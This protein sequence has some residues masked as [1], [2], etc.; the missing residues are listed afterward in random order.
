VKATGDNVKLRA[1]FPA[2]VVLVGVAIVNHNLAGAGSV[3]LVSGSGLNEAITVPAN[4]G[5]QSNAPILDFSAALLAQRTSTTFDLEV[6]GG[7]L[8]NIAIGQIV[9][10]TAIRDFRWNWG[11]KITPMRLVSRRATFGATHLQYDKRI[12]IYKITGRVDLQTE[13]A[14]MVFLEEEAEGENHP[15]IIWPVVAV[16]VCYYVKF[17]PGTFSWTWETFGFT[18][19]PLE[20]TEVSK[21]PPLFP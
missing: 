12:R 4:T 16:G 2:P 21:G 10:L 19:M 1:T 5:R 7:V 6:A 18:A 11:V 13:E 3:V 20:A 14:A 9:L 8:G 17:D 15:W